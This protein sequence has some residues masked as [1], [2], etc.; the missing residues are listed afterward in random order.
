MQ[1]SYARALSHV[2]LRL[3]SFFFFGL[4]LYSTSL[5][6]ARLTRRKRSPS[7]RFLT[8]YEVGCLLTEMARLS[9]HPG[10]LAVAALALATTA[11]A[12]SAFPACSTGGT[13]TDSNGQTYSITCPADSNS[14]NV[15]NV[16]SYTFDGCVNYCDSLVDCGVV[17][18]EPSASPASSTT[19]G[20][21]YAKVPFSTLYGF[22]ITTG[23]NYVAERVAGAASSS[24]SPSSNP[25]TSTPTAT[26]TGTYNYN[27]TCTSGISP[28]GGNSGT[29]VDSYGATYNILC[30]QD[31]VPSNYWYSGGTNGQGIDACMRG[32]DRSSN[33]TA[34]Y[35]AG[36]LS[37]GSNHGC[38]GLHVADIA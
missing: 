4:L 2:P 3:P 8:F 21:C 6:H 23:N 33:C 7:H 20:L 13:Y 27:P 11:N 30:G 19:T 37:G 17:V 32:C 9:L 18:W 24:S 25:A 16:G 14:R 34:F 12:Q 35:F 26:V 22:S 28:A 5:I 1:Q 36:T 15:G 38:R 10:R 29:I 31:H